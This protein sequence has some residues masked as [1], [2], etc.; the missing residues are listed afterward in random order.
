VVKGGYPTP[1]KKGGKLSGRGKYVR[2]ECPD[3]ND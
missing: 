2:G 1:C 3:P